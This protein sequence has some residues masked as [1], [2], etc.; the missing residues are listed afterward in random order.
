MAIVALSDRFQLSKGTSAVDLLLQKLLPVLDDG[1]SLVAL[2]S[3]PKGIVIFIAYLLTK[4]A[5]R[6]DPYAHQFLNPF[7]PQ[8]A[9]KIRKIDVG[10][11]FE[12]LGGHGYGNAKLLRYGL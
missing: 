10:A 3:P 6:E 9:D 5:N 7:D 1:D 4:G 8:P 12:Y 2:E 11:G